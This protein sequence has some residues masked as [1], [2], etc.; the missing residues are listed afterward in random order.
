ME[1]PKILGSYVFW[2][3][4]FEEQHGDEY[5]GHCLCGNLS[6]NRPETPRL[7]VNGTTGAFS[8]KVCGVEGSW[9]DYLEYIHN[10]YL[11]KTS[12]ADLSYM[13][14]MEGIPL[15]ALKQGKVARNDLK[16]FVPV[17]DEQFKLSDLRLW[18]HGRREYS[19]TNGKAGIFNLLQLR[20]T[21][22]ENLIYLCGSFRDALSLQ[23]L[24]WRTKQKGVVLGLPGENTF[25][26][27][28]AYLLEGKDLIICF[29]HD[30][31][32]YGF[33]NEETGK[34]GGGKKVWLRTRELC[35]SVGYLK[36]PEDSKKGYDVKDFI[37]EYKSKPKSGFSKIC[38]FI[39]T[40]SPTAT[41]PSTGNND[42]TPAR[43]KFTFDALREEC[44]N[45]YELNRDFEN[46]IKVSLATAL[47]HKIPGNNNVWMF[48]VGASGSG[49]TEI[50][51]MFM[52]SK[53]HTLWQS[54]LTS[55]SLI[56][57][58][59]LGKSLIDPSILARVNQKCL[60]VNDFTTVLDS[61][62]ERKEVF[63]ILRDAYF[64]FV[65]RPFGN[66]ERIYNSKFSCLFGV[67]PVIQ[68]YNNTP[69]GERFLRYRMPVL[70]GIES[71]AL[72]IEL[73]GGE[74]KDKIKYI[75]N[76][77]FED[78]K[79]F[80]PKYLAAKIPQWFKDKIIPLSKLCAN[81]RTAI[82]RHE[83]GLRYGGLAYQPEKETG[84]R[85]ATQFQ[86]L[87][88]GLCLLEEKPMVDE[89]IYEICK[90]VAKDTISDFEYKIVNTLVKLNTKVNIQELS[91]LTRVEHL[92]FYLKD[93]QLLNL[94]ERN[95]DTPP[96]YYASKLSKDL[97]ARA[98]L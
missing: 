64:G 96:V 83:K 15:P 17:Y 46:A 2:G 26:N 54:T 48:L 23:W 84:S 37:K 51:E 5:V 45:I 44:A 60:I 14:K 95:G 92:G 25:R 88:L 43:C 89:E 66:G 77:Y 40:F 57:G 39:D 3:V 38:S 7:Y 12:D 65:R 81:M 67:T 70:E 30:E 55:K 32:G 42:G 78:D 73:F 29:D 22:K 13:T 97:F 10:S 8:C 59:G 35:K 80:E 98:G 94:I 28:W 91:D 79:Q 76:D 58:L 21:P 52:E 82:V 16:Y 85:I 75:V 63:S 56:S 9:R 61:E 18:R 72:D 34:C 41:K 33:V 49:K 74:S 47:S 68:Q 27:E 31:S 69:L 86:K 62:Y 1:F 71:K 6:S 36:W 50:C 53:K 87:A 20:D 19:T 4:E 90:K 11:K 93:L 24:L